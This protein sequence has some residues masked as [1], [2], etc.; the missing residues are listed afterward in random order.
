[1]GPFER[2]V[3]TALRPPHWQADPGV[4][5]Q[6]LARKVHAAPDFLDLDGGAGDTDRHGRVWRLRPWRSLGLGFSSYINTRCCQQAFR[7]PFQ[8]FSRSRSIGKLKCFVKQ[9]ILMRYLECF[10]N[11]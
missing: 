1:M 3:A 10:V 9:F 4:P 8:I 7:I 2:Q 11:I 5:A 6:G